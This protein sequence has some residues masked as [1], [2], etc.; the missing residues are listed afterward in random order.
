MRL[1]L[2]REMVWEQ[3]GNKAWRPPA[4]CWGWQVAEKGHLGFTLASQAWKEG[5]PP[6]TIEGVTRWTVASHGGRW[7]DKSLTRRRCLLLV[8]LWH[9]PRPPGQRW[10]Q[11]V[12][13]IP[14][15]LCMTPKAAQAGCT[16]TRARCS[17]ALHLAS[18][19][20]GGVG[21]PETSPVCW[22]AEPDGP[23]LQHFYY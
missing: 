18:E 9:T 10:S 1:W 20:N 2:W 8:P 17:A 4:P 11:P 19:A 3:S 21:L 7:D 22:W 13:G 5:V 6:S 16:C 12:R 15:Y 14:E 23:A